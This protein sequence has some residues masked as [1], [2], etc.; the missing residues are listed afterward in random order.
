[1]GTESAKTPDTYFAPA[2]RDTPDEV[3]RQRKSVQQHPLLSETL[4]AIPGMVMLLNAKRQIVAANEAV[5]RFLKAT[6]KELAAKR[7]GEAVHC[8]HAK[9]GPDGCGTGRHC[10]T[11]GAVEAILGSQQ[12]NRQIVRECHVQAETAEGVSPLDLRVTATPITVAGARYVVLAIEDISQAKRLAVFQRVF[13]HDVLNTAGCIAG[14]SHYLTEQ[15]EDLEEVSESLV[16]L[17]D[18]LVEEIT[19]QRDL[20]AAESGELG[21]QVEEVQTQEVLEQLRA[22]YLKSPVAKDR[23][24]ELGLVWQGEIGTDRSLLMRVLGNMLKNGLEATAKDEAVTMDCLDQGA[25]VVFAVHNSGI[26]PETVQLQIFQRSF[27]TKGQPGRGIGTYSMKLLGERYLGGQVGFV[28]RSPEGTTFT[29]TIPKSIP[30][31]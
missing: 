12:Q 10:A 26:M 2:G 6:S 8:A 9:Q 14:Y 25:Q 22:A 3:A 24:I 17:S 18:Q 30:K 15:R 13:F 16:R 27:S 7:P 19:A 11:C 4:N 31:G 1:M 5:F 21:V 20:M 23:R 29:L 28:S